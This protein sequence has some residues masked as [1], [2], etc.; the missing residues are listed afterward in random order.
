MARLARL[1]KLATINFDLFLKVCLYETWR[2]IY[3]SH[4]LSSTGLWE[5]HVLFD[6]QDVLKRD[7]SL[8]VIDI[9]ANL[10][11]YTL[12]AAQMGHQVVIHIICSFHH[13]A[14]L[15]TMLVK[16]NATLIH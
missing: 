1:L 16:R 6:F 9:G 11:V 5:P 8:G 15:S 7:S 2:D 10:G 3:V 13:K 4:D 12:L 14:T